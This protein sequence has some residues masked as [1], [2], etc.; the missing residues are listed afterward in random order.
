MVHRVPGLCLL[1]GRRMKYRIIIWV[2]C[3]SWHCTYSIFVFSSFQFC[4]VLSVFG[5][6]DLPLSSAYIAASVVFAM[7]SHVLRCWAA[8]R[9][10]ARASSHDNGDKEKVAMVMPVAWIAAPEQSWAI[11]EGFRKPGG[12]HDGIKWY[13]SSNRLWIAEILR[14]WRCM[15]IVK[16]HCCL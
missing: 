7:K 10:K 9:G 11:A 15:K 12:R 16:W 8:C 13:Y 3:I 5:P 4:H 1:L 14:I 2:H 6:I